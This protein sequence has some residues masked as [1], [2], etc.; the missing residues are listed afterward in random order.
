MDVIKIPLPT[1]A[2]TEKLIPS[3]ELSFPEA[4]MLD[5]ISGAPFPKAKNV[6]PAKF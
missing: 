3:A 6:T 5:I 1:K 2:P 4:T